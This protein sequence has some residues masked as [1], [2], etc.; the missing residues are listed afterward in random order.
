[1]AYII[2]IGPAHPFRGGIAAFN[3]RL[4]QTWQAMGHKVDIITFTV[5]YPAILFPGKTQYSDSDRP[6]GISIKRELNSINPLSWVKVGW[7]VKKAK[8]DILFLRFWLPFLAPSLG[9]VARIAKTNKSTKVIALTDNVIPHESRPGDELLTQYFI[10]ACDAFVSMSK[11]VTEDLAKFTDKKEVF[12]QPHPLYD[13]FGP[14]IEKQEAKRQL[15]LSDKPYLLFFGFIREYK[16]LDLLLEAM[17]DVRLA[18]LNLNLIVAGEYY[19]EKERYEA[20]IE[21]RKLGKRVV[22][23]TEY[24]P[25]TQVAAYFCASD[26]VVQ[27]YK[28]ATQSGVTQI[29]YYYNKPMVVTN[30]GGLPEIVPAGKVG[31]V[32]SIK[33]KA[34]ADA[35]YDYYSN[36]REASFVKGVQEEKK[37]FSWEV[38]GKGIL[39]LAG[40]L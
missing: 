34:I 15:G 24:I 18:N 5:Q 8:P 1:M 11:S 37:R 2:L 6:E 40:R 16:G 25:D 20:I 32:V 30:V 36:E 10:N 29:A 7:K 23:H 33:V 31:Y 21:E 39:E 13:V 35:I 38:M 12:F 4:A 3:E 9:T 22:L 14:A 17:A 28:T 27:P 19:E 26:L